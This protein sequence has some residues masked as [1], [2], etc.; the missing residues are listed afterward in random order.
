MS[1]WQLVRKAGTNETIFKFHRTNKI[2]AGAT[3]TVWASDIGANHDP[4][5]NIVMKS[6]KWFVADNMTT[7]LLNNDGEVC[8]NYI[9][10]LPIISAML[11]F[12]ISTIVL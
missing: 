7:T 9:N 2:D 3:V 6:Q 1:G 8:L 10:L 5:A 4:P 12:S 11:F